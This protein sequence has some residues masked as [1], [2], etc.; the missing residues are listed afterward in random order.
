MRKEFGDLRID[1]ASKVRR[2][3]LRARFSVLGCSPDAYQRAV[4]TAMPHA[5][6]YQPELCPILT[7]HDSFARLVPIENQIPVCPLLDDVFI[8]YH[9]LFGRT[10]LNA[11]RTNRFPSRSR[12]T[13]FRGMDYI[14]GALILV[15][16]DIQFNRASS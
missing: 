1:S 7:R 14:A 13:V 11:R 8:H 9:R 10:D 12:Q 15:I 5:V 6:S 3:R 4:R 16:T 2:T